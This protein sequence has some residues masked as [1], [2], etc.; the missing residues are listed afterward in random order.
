MG[1]NQSGLPIDK[2]ERQKIRYRAHHRGTREMDWLVGRFVDYLLKTKA[3]HSDETALLLF[4]DMTDADIYDIFYRHKKPEAL[5]DYTPWET[6]QL[7]SLFSQM[8]KFYK[9]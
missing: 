2:K 6:D 9:V 8:Q 4:L 5:T 7:K 3:D 1:A